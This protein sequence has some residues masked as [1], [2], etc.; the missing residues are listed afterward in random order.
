MSESVDEVDEAMH[1]KPRRPSHSASLA[2]GDEGDDDE[3]SLDDDCNGRHC[4][5]DVL[6]GGLRERDRSVNPAIVKR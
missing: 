1:A 2:A 4:H 6:A 3:E 5:K